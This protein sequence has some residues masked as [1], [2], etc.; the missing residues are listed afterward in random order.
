LCTVDSSVI[1]GKEIKVIN[2]I[3]EKVSAIS[4]SKFKKETSIRVI[5]DKIQKKLIAHSMESD[6]YKFIYVQVINC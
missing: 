6:K 2:N 3:I 4:D 1:C 5:I